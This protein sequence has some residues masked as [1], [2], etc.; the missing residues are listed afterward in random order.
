MTVTVGATSPARVFRGPRA[1]VGVRC[2]GGVDGRRAAA[3]TWPSGHRDQLIVTAFGGRTRLAELRGAMVERPSWVLNGVGSMSFHISAY[4]P[5]LL[6]CLVVPTSVRAGSGELKLLGREVQWWRD[7]ELRWAGVPVAAEVSAD[8][9]VSFECFDLGWYLSR[10]FFGSAQRRDLLNGRGSMDRPGLP[11]WTRTGAI[12]AVR[13]TSIKRRGTGS[14]QVSGSGAL[15][16]SFQHPPHLNEGWIAVYVTAQVRVQAATPVGELLIS[17]ASY[18]DSGDLIFANPEV[19][20]VGVD[21]TT[22]LG[23]WNQVTCRTLV[24]PAGCE[25]RVVLWNATTGNRYFDDVR[26]LKNDTTGYPPPGEDLAQHAV[27]VLN[28]AQNAEGKSSFGFKPVIM[29]PTGT[30][31]PMGVRHLDH[32]QVL[33]VLGAYTDREDGFDWWIEPW[34]REFRIAPRRGI[35]HDDATLHDRAVVS[36]GWVHDDSARATAVVVP[37]E[38]SGPERPEGGYIDATTTDGIILDE[39]HRPGNN[40]PLSALDPLARQIHARDSQPQVKPNGVK[41]PGSWWGEL[42]EPGDYYPAE[43]TVGVLRASAGLRVTEV[44]HDLEA[45]VLEVS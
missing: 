27:A 40:T 31:E 29:E 22:V 35:D 20:R 30:V 25:V 37:G 23:G 26:A 36:A 32:P 39:Y 43:F 1:R 7:G 33:D 13:N 15:V 19:D 42:C 14:A 16:A 18:D 44:V 11:G 12:T 45:D 9:V 34:T 8:G 24:P 4:D 10:R 28:H 38:G 17:A 3:A 21:S 41:L 5:A 2:L 6:D